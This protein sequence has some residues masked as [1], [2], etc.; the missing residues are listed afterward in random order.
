MPNAKSFSVWGMLALAALLWPASA[1]A[2]RGGGSHGG[3]SRGGG[4]MRA[5]GGFHGGGFSGGGVRGSAVRGGGFVG[6]NAGAFRGGFAGHTGF[7]GGFAGFNRGFSRPFFGSSF[8]FSLGYGYWPYSY[9]YYYPYPYS[10]S[11]YSQDPYYYAPSSSYY[12]DDPPPS[13]A[14]PYPGV[15]DRGYGDPGGYR[16]APRGAQPAQAAHPGPVAPATGNYWLIAFRDRTI[17]AATDY[18]LEGNTLHYVS[19]DGT[20]SAADLAAVDITFTQQLNRER[21]LEFHLPSSS[22]GSPPRQRDSFGRPQ[23]Q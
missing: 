23:Y 21:G 7:R 15:V 19:R 13:S 18:W 20:K 8:G 2:Q 17:Q 14:A 10:Y 12:Y 11:Y 3:G 4:G 6:G 5:G 9:P 16:S 22:G 1:W